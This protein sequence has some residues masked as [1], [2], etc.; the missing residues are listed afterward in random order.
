VLDF[1]FRLVTIKSMS[2][3]FTCYPASF[4]HEGIKK[5]SQEAADVIYPSQ[6][7]DTDEENDRIC[8]SIFENLNKCPFFA[9]LFHCY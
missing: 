2:Q 8:C 7:Y 4:R 9:F 3:I 1:L 6:G 5:I